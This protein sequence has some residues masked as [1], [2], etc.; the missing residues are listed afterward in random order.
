MT[1]P[2]SNPERQQIAFIGL[3]SM[4]MGMASRLAQSGFPIAVYNRTRSKSERVGELGARVA[5]SPADAVRDAD[6]VMLSVADQHVVTAMLFGDQGVFGALR[7][8]GCIIDMSTVP[9]GFARE[10]SG[11]ARAGG[12]RAVDACVLGNPKQAR[13]GELRVMVGGED[14]DVLAVSDV[15]RTV[16]REVTHLG[17]N[18]MG[19][20][21]K[22]VLNMLMG[23]QMASL[24]EAVVLG[25]MA[26]LPRD[27]ILEMIA[28]SGFSSLVMKFRCE[29]MKTRAFENAS[30][31]LALMRKDMLLALQESHALGVPLPVADSAF[32][33]LTAAQRQGL[34]HLDVGAI[35]AFQERQSGMQDYPWPGRA[36]PGSRAPEGET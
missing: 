22:L 28:A 7:H 18:G 14:A 23:V 29:V 8:G 33:A 13:D 12:Y 35:V 36:A 5:A 17:S 20:T 2:H 9:P 10:L 34:G 1:E 26:G 19:A 16:G 21:M 4:G 6:V 3:G 30:F 25:E 32:L 31:K 15:L 27:T 11:K 24:A